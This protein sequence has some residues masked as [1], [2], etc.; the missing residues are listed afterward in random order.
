MSARDL[1]NSYGITPLSAGGPSGSGS[2]ISLGT[3]PI[4]NSAAVH[5]VRIGRIG[6]FRYPLWPHR[7]RD[8]P[9][10]PSNR[11]E[12]FRAIQRKTDCDLCGMPN[13]DIIHMCYECTHPTIVVKRTKAMDELKGQLR[14]MATT[15]ARAL[16]AQVPSEVQ[17]AIEELGI[18]SPEAEFL[19]TRIL[20][21]TTWPLSACPPGDMTIA[22]FFGRL[23]D[24]P[25]ASHADLREFAN[26]WVKWAHLTIK[27]VCLDW[28]TL[29]PQQQRV[30]LDPALAPH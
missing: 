12:H 1:G 28:C 22:R 17:L 13:G 19:V 20:A 27:Y 15:L 8:K 26:L 4:R 16:D 5:N 25:P 18:P 30:A 14:C 6:L 9:G 10:G 29:I 2:I 11:R 23:F 3:I 24:T 21:A 7:Q